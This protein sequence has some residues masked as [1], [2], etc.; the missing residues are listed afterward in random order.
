MHVIQSYDSVNQHQPIYLPAYADYWMS[1]LLRYEAIAASG[2]IKKDPLQLQVLA[3]LQ[4]LCD[5]LGLADSA[6]IQQ[7]K[8]FLPF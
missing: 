4:K 6:R 5:K 2:L 1:L 3:K 7:H 8:N